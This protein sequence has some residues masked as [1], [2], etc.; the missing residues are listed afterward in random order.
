MNNEKRKPVFI[1][2][3]LLVLIGLGGSV[4]VSL[5]ISHDRKTAI[6]NESKRQLEETKAQAEKK[7]MEQAIARHQSQMK[8][9]NTSP[10]TALEPTPTAP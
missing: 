7:A 1:F 9:T 6:L 3:L 2:V 10:N 4:A 8:S 5:K